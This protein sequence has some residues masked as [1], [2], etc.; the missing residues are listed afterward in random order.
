M[1]KVAEIIKQAGI[2]EVRKESDTIKLWESYRDQALLWRSIALI[3]V[4]GILALTILT[5]MVFIGRETV[6]NVPARPAPGIYSSTEIPDAEYVEFATEF[7]NLTATYQPVGARTQF[8]E[9]AKRLIEPIYSK[10]NNE[11]LD[12]ELKTIEQTQRTQ[13]FFVDPT[14]TQIERA[15]GKVTVLMTGDRIKT[16][17]GRQLPATGTTYRV[18]MS[19]IPRNSL[20]PYGI[21]IENISISKGLE[22]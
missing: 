16:I 4:P 13:M 7:V 8:T 3:Q 19:I 15:N 17:S 21:A 5:M 9:A 11:I 6:V 2:I 20:N 10:F 22:D 12:T 14:K 18:T 1:A